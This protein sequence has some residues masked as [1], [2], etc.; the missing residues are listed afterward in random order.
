MPPLYDD[1]VGIPGRD[2]AFKN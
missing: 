2:S 1:P